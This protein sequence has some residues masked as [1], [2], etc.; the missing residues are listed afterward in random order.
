MKAK[1]LKQIKVQLDL[2]I[3]LKKNLYVKCLHHGVGVKDVALH[4]LEDVVALHHQGVVALR[5]QNAVVMVIVEVVDLLLQKKR[6]T[7]QKR[8]KKFENKLLKLE[9]KVQSQH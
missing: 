4:L 1:N 7:R 2:R 5:H 9:Y 6:P 3:F 8:R